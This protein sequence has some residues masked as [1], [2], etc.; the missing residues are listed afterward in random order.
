MHEGHLPYHRGVSNPQSEHIKTVFVLDGM[1][2]TSFG[3][4]S[5][6]QAGKFRINL[7][8]R[9]YIKS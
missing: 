1:I 6:P 2:G 8:T 9:A 3:F 7:I 4:F 5:P